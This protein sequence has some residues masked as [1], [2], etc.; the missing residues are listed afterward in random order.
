MDPFRL[1]AELLFGVVLVFVGAGYL[2]R[3]DAV[4]RDL[5]LAFAGLGFTFVIEVWRWLAGST[6]PLVG[7][8]VGVLLLLQPL[9][10][11]HLVSLIRDV[12][13]GILL[14]ATLLLLGSVAAAIVFRP[15]P[16]PSLVAVAAFIG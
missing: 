16:G 2:R 3:R 14:G 7:L 5:V 13:R 11:L 8:V 12:S 6:P 10:I 9:F 4:S 15:A 1:T